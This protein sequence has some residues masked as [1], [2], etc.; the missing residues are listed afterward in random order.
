VPLTPDRRPGILEEDEA[1]K[2]V[3]Q[4]A[5]PSADG[6][7]R[8]VTGVGFRFLEEGIEKGLS[9]SGITEPQHESLDS[10]THWLAESGYD[11][12][13]YSGSDLV[14]TT[15]WTSP[16][17]TIKV[18]EEQLTYSGGK[19]QQIVSIQYDAA[20]LETYR[21]TEVMTYS[22]NKITSIARTRV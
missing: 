2:L 10:L 21:V 6:E 7:L 12:N 1:I 18:R 20:G 11:E 13:T 22:G 19:V 9:G 8:Y 17:K 15:T 4:G 14:N 3:P 5:S 16:A